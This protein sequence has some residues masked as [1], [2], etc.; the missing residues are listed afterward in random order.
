MRSSLAYGF[1]LWL[2]ATVVF[3]LFGGF[4]LVPGDG[5][6]LV[7]LFVATVPGVAALM[8]VLYAR[9]GLDG[10]KRAM[11]AVCVVLPGMLLDVFALA[12]FRAVYPNL[13]FAAAPVFGAFLLWAYALVLLTGFLPARA[14]RRTA[15]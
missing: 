10:R 2:A 7:V 9:K 8:Y 15:A 1:G 5:V 6:R 3:R 13:E 4:V 12:F 14:G 11:A